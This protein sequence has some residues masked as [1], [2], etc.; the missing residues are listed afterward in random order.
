MMENKTCILK[1]ELLD[2]KAR[3]IKGSIYHWSQVT[4]AYNS[5]KIEGSRL[6]EDQTEQIFDTNNVF[7]KK[8]NDLLRLDDLIEA[9]NHFRLFD[10]MLDTISVPITKEY[11]IQMNTI[12]NKGTSY[13]DDSRYNVGGFK[14]RPNIIGV[15]NVIHTSSPENV[16]KDIDQ[17]LKD[18]N[19]LTKVQF[20]D[21]VSFHVQ[22]ERIHPFGDGNGRVGRML[23]FKQYLENDIFP[24]IVLDRDR[25][26]YIR[27]LREWDKNHTYLMETLRMQQD[28]YF[29]VCQQLQILDKTMKEEYKIDITL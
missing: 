19:S 17:L 9:K 27:G 29:D 16:E 21:I 18:Y 13:E 15:F 4:F 28:V 1:E 2:Q 11:L 25:D 7:A 6:T 24:F 14:T 3:K 22:F 23:M 12:L 20:E 10:F 26:F 5:N 8:E